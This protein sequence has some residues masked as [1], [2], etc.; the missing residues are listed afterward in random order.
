MASPKTPKASRKGSAK[1]TT[2][3]DPCGATLDSFAGRYGFTVT[4]SNT[5]TSFFNDRCSQEIVLENRTSAPKAEKVMAPE[6]A[7]TPAADETTNR[8]ATAGP[9]VAIKTEADCS[10]QPAVPV[11]L[12]AAGTNLMLPPMPRLPATALLSQ[13]SF[14]QPITPAA[15]EAAQRPAAASPRSSPG[16]FRT[17]ST[18]MPAGL[19]H[20]N[21]SAQE[22]QALA[23]A[24]AAEAASAADDSHHANHPHL[25]PLQQLSNYIKS[26]PD[27]SSEVQQQ[28]RHTGVLQTPWQPDGTAGGWP[29]GLQGQ[30]AAVFGGGD[31]WSSAPPFDNKGAATPADAVMMPPDRWPMQSLGLGCRFDATQQY[32]ATH[33]QEQQQ[34]QQAQM[35]TT[36]S[37]STSCKPGSPSKGRNGGSPSKSRSPGSPT[38]HNSSGNRQ[39]QYVTSAAYQCILRRSLR[40]PKLRGARY[41]PSAKTTAAA[42]AR[43]GTGARLLGK[44]RL[45]NC[46]SVED[47]G[48]EGMPHEWVGNTSMTNMHGFDS[49][50]D[51]AHASGCLGEAGSLEM[52]DSL[53]LDGFEGYVL[54]LDSTSAEDGMQLQQQPPYACT[55]AAA[56][57]AAAAGVGLGARRASST[58]SD[59]FRE[60]GAQDLAGSRRCSLF[61][62]CISVNAPAAAG[63]DGI[64]YFRCS[65]ADVESEV[66]RGL[67][68]VPVYGVQA[69]VGQL[70]MQCLIDG[71]ITPDKFY[72]GLL[73]Q[74]S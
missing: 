22:R 6:A 44:H 73:F 13:L 45:S 27:P 11:S 46:S 7:A 68:Y 23:A 38:R 37:R 39:Q 56:A 71:G 14:Q 53:G 33:Q 63:G 67:A 69:C 50:D 66:Q 16:F 9:T 2:D 20:S 25:N 58:S 70:G 21:S 36:R 30:A 48:P 17:V 34:Q 24:A 31:T 3:P 52:A 26:L 54:P 10:I 60:I 32:L 29:K 8:P 74:G 65:D 40:R 35:Q 49:W 42:A 28:Q 62:D 43:Y 5:C 59:W 4:T 61:N 15:Q 41:D 18:G 72:D 51:E 55:P 47:A 19:L 1:D 64:N 57:A 12:P